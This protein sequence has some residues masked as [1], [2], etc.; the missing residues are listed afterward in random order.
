MRC[1][2]LATPLLM[3][4]MFAV[5]FARTHISGMRASACVG[6]CTDVRNEHRRTL[7]VCVNAFLNRCATECD[8]MP[9]SDNHG[10]TTQCTGCEYP[11]VLSM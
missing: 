5:F 7:F 8:G 1:G 4:R 10:S 3:G 6:V 9:R 11:F 2:Y